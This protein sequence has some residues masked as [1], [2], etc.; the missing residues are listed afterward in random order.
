MKNSIAIINYGINNIFSLVKAFDQ[1]DVKVEVVDNHKKLKHFSHYVLPGV[2]SFER[3]VINLEKK[4]LMDEIRF[5]VNKGNF[6]M[7]ICLGMQLLFECS[8]ESENESYGLSLI[9]GKCVKF[10]HYNKSNIR[11]PHIGWNSVNKARPSK[12]LKN[13][14]RN[15]DFYFV[16]SYYVKPK[17][18]EFTVGVCRHGIEFAA[19]IE[20]DNILG[21]QFHPEKCS[22]NGL[23]ILRQFSLLS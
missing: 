20:S 10:K 2:G 19:V 5:L 22:K 3:G 13:V 6:I 18:P 17:N 15:S 11:V 14:Q 21:L 7:G 12:L 8:E 16:H 23:D 1:I 4:N 9:K